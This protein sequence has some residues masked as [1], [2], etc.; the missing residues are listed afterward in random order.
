MELSD[1]DDPHDHS[2]ADA[3]VRMEVNGKHD[4][5]EASARSRPWRERAQL[6]G[7]RATEGGSVGRP[8][9]CCEYDL[10]RQVEQHL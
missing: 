7:E 3:L 1:V 6:S 2:V 10:D 5:P 8:A 4:S 9:V